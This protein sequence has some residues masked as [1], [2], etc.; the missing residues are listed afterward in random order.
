MHHHTQLIFVFLVETG[1]HHV[2]HAGLELLTSSDPPASASQSAEITGHKCIYLDSTKCKPKKSDTKKYSGFH[3][4]GKASLELLTSGDP[5]TL[6]YQSA[7]ITGMSHNTRPP[8]FLFTI[9]LFRCEVFSDLY[10]FTKSHQGFIIIII[11][12]ILLNIRKQE[13]ANL[14]KWKEQN[15]AKPVHLVPRRLDRDLW[16]SGAGAGSVMNCLGCLCRLGLTLLPRLECSGVITAASIFWVQ[17]WGFTMLPSL[18]SNFWAQGIHLLRPPKKSSGDVGSHSDR[19]SSLCGACS[20][21]RVDWIP[22]QHLWSFVLVAQAGVQCCDL[23]SLQP[24]S[25]G[26]KRFFCFNLLSYWDYKHLPPHPANFLEAGFCHVGQA[27]LELLTLG[28]PPTSASQSA[29]ITGISHLTQ[30]TN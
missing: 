17:R 22:C 16:A 26:F 14:E 27:G 12:I 8:L 10:R 18:V 15:R 3:Y 1:F 20:E 28:D 23:S 11:I 21:E 9:G 25:P 29:G 13:L 7:G 2:G 30:P 5:P 4:V 6:S 19:L 24:S